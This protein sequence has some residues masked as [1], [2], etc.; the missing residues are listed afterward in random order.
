ML[1]EE[2]VQRKKTHALSRREPRAFMRRMPGAGRDKKRA[3]AHL[4]SD[5]D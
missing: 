4:I 5:I 3:M 2:K 1:V